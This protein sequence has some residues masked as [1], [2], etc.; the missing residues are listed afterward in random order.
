MLEELY[1]F[2]VEYLST[3]YYICKSINRDPACNSPVLGIGFFSPCKKEKYRSFIHHA[4][5]LR[6]GGYRSNDVLITN[7]VRSWNTNNILFVF[8][9]IFVCLVFLNSIC[10]HKLSVFN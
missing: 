3:Y 10:S 1:L 2:V 7:I 6:V 8:R 4:A 5:P 9:S